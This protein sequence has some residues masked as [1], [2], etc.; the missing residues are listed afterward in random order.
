MQPTEEK[1][2]P[3]QH[4]QSTAKPLEEALWLGFSNMHPQTELPKQN[5]KLANLQV[6]PTKTPAAAVESPKIEFAFN[7]E[8]T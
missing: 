6:T 3:K 7:R 5:N 4:Q 2:H 1:M 8:D